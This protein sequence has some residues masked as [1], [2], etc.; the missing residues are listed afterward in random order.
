MNTNGHESRQGRENKWM[1][2]IKKRFVS[3]RV[4]SWL[5]FFFLTAIENKGNRNVT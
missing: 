2:E 5:K 3:I 1:I 4:H